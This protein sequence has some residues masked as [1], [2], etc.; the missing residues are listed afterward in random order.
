MPVFSSASPWLSWRSLFAAPFGV[1]LLF[2]TG[3]F[4]AA[5]FLGS[6]KATR[7]ATGLR[8]FGGASGILGMTNPLLC[9]AV[10]IGHSRGW[11]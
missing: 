8:T 9:L 2:F 7:S 6:G 11:G 3:F 5:A 1:Y 10:G 4:L